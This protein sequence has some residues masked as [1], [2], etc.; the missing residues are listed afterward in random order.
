MSVS[1]VYDGCGTELL[2][3]YKLLHTFDEEKLDYNEEYLVAT[4]YKLQW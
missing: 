1:P 3:I 2:N 4:Q